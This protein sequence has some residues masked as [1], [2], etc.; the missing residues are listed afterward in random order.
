MKLASL[1]LTFAVVAPAVVCAQ[2]TS[3][4]ADAARQERDR[5][6]NSTSRILVTNE[7]LGTTPEDPVPATPS[8]T[9]KPE[10]DAK[11]EKAGVATESTAASTDPATPP[12]RDEK[13]WKEN[14]KA[15]RDEAKRTDDRVQVL[16]LEYN[17]LNMDMLTRDDIYNKEGQ[18]GH[19]LAS[20]KAELETAS[21]DADKAHKKLTQ[22][23][24]DLR[25]SGSPIGWS[26]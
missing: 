3:P 15:A 24:D 4:I 20:K 8:A 7:T 17:K 9:A 21:K 19:K 13:W 22:L 14:F 5:Q 18:L 25:R 16:T 2:T 23:E 11:T 6:K 1:V 26:R 12:V 10:S